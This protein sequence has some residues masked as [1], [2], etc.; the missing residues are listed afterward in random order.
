MKFNFVHVHRQ[1]EG[2]EERMRV[3]VKLF[4]KNKYIVYIYI[5]MLLGLEKNKIL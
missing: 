4:M 2:G 5:S 3:R 1:E